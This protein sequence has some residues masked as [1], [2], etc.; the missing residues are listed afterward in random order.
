MFALLGVLTEWPGALREGQRPPGSPGHRARVTVAGIFRVVA[1][2][3]IM[4][5]RMR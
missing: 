3:A 5:W 2:G 4:W 1:A